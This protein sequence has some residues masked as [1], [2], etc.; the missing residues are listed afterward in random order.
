MGKLFLSCGRLLCI[1]ALFVA[2]SVI[3]PESLILA[4][5]NVTLNTGETVP[6]YWYNGKWVKLDMI[7]EYKNGSVFCID[8]NNG[9]V[10]C[11]GF[12]FNDR[13]DMKPVYWKSGKMT[14]LAINVQGIDSIS[15]KITCMAIDSDDIYFGGSLDILV[16]GKRR[17][18]AA[19]WK[20]DQLTVI[21]SKPNEVWNYASVDSLK[22]R[23]HDLVAGG[24]I[25][26]QDGNQFPVIWTMGEWSYLDVPKN[27]S[28]ILFDNICIFNNKVVVAATYLDKTA[29]G[30]DPTWGATNPMFWVEGS[31]NRLQCPI[32]GKRCWSRGIAYLDSDQYLAGNIEQNL[33][34]IMNG[35]NAINSP[36]YWK[37]GKWNMLPVLQN[38]KSSETTSIIATNKSIVIGGW[39]VDIE[40]SRKA[41]CWIDGNIFVLE[42]SGMKQRVIKSEITCLSYY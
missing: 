7:S 10:I 29:E 11:G 37:N 4:G 21:P 17:S 20:N 9:N 27:T 16:N 34:E 33:Q 41:V 39:A 5:G 32:E 1:I 28:R 14:V 36:G 3:F 24:M 26:N 22:I 15:G 31:P 8:A 30:V 13:N 25:Q 12:V 38:G 2:G 40:N 23:N 6:G 42:V 19:I 35:K 18:V